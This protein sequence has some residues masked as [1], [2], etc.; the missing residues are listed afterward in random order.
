MRTVQESYMCNSNAMDP[1][2]NVNDLNKSL[3]SFEEIA[4]ACMGNYKFRYLFEGVGFLV[5]SILI[6]NVAEIKRINQNGIKKM[7]RNIFAIQQ[8]LTNITMSR[9]GDL[10]RARQYYELL[11][12]NPDEILTSI[13]E[14]D[15]KFSKREYTDLLSLHARSQAVRDNSAHEQRME[16]LKKI[17]DNKLKMEE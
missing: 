14:Q 16:R 4:T 2:K 9:E 7:C 15:A 6:S 1:D 8:N 11:Y 10:D 5:S 3:S 17:F 12:S 13:E